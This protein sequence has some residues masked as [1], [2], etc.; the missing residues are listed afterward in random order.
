MG[1]AHAS[2]SVV[3]SFE[4]R[5]R[6]RILHWG[7]SDFSQSFITDTKVVHENGPWPLPSVLLHIQCSR[8]YHFTSYDPCYKGTDEPRVRH[9][10]EMCYFFLRCDLTDINWQWYSA[11]YVVCVIVVLKGWRYLAPL[12]TCKFST[13]RR[14]CGDISYIWIYSHSFQLLI[15]RIFNRL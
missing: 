8:F 12:H 14:N 9:V 3:L 5:L 15:L 7:S 2:Y 13:Y 4:S 6:D 1:N 11:A 10:R